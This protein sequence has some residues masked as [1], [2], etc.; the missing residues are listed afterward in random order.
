M[1]KTVKVSNITCANCAKSIEG[2][3]NKTYDDINARV[4]VSASSVVFSYDE[5]K[6]SEDF[7]YDELLDLGYYGVKTDEAQKKAIRK[8]RI[9][10]LVGIIF[11]IPLLLTMLAHLGNVELPNILMNGYFQWIITTPVLFF[12]GRRFFVG[13]Y[14]SIKAKNLGMDALVVIGTTSAYIYSIYETISGSGHNLFFETTAVIITMVLIGNYFENRIKEKTSQT[15]TGL[16]SLGSKQATVIKD[17]KEVLTNIDDVKVGD[18]VI[19]KGNEKVP[20][21]GI[22]V[23]GKTYVDESMLTGESMPVL[24]EVGSEVVGS[25]MNILETIKI[26]VTKVGSETVLAKIIQ[27]VEETALIKPEAQRIA[28]K[29]SGFFVP[30]VILISVVVFLIYLLI[31]KTTFADA[32]MPAIAILVVSCPCALGLATPTSISV[33]SGMAFKK[34]ILYKG[35]EFFETANKITAIAFDKTGTLTKG[36]P[37]ITNYIGDEKY[38]K[39]TASLE[40]HSNHPIS[41]A[42]SDYYKGDY[43]KV[44]DYE[45]LIGYGIKGKIDNKDVFVVSI[46]YLEENNIKNPYND[47]EKYLKE[48]KTIFFT[49]INN[50]VFNMI[51]ISDELKETSYELVE[52]LKARNITPYMITGDQ[53]L[54]ARYIANKLGIKHVYAKVLPHE[55]ANIIKDIQT[56]EDFVAFVGDG[57]NDA[58]A[59]KMADLGFAIGTGSDIAID[60]SDVTLM[61][62]DM[63][64]VLYA[65]DLSK[66]TLKNIY[67]NFFW[68]F[69]YNIAMIPLAAF[70]IFSPTI[71]GIG[72]AFSSLMVVLNAL[73]LKRWKISK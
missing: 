47:Y 34:G 27:T 20:I 48:G 15:L 4:N 63:M 6:Y 72:M 66:A 41:N 71:A 8:D 56:K 23:E 16:I 68:A 67:L 45:T 17:G 43:F 18:I 28:D 59:L 50:S 13:A 61:Q 62:D 51:A 32:L 31:V 29:I 64:S 19:I 42:F 21:D 52:K 54:T 44:L 49:V 3:F 30:I 60:T 57:I 2:H 36:I 37:V 69:I 11:S 22:I 7:L 10:L 46:S 33:S 40:K 58:P 39:Y 38:L 25:S 1:R 55:K 53:E 14:H 35:G 65:I 9:D 70:G 73:S 26:R 24:K 12:A 5:N